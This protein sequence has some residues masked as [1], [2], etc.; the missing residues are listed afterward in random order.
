MPIHF[1]CT[2]C[3]RCCQ[4]LKLPLSVPEAIAWLARGGD[5]QLLCEAFAWPG[6]YDPTPQAAYG[7]HRSF[8]AVSD[9]VP[10]RIAVT[11]VGAFAGDCP[12]LLADKRC[13]GYDDRPGVCRIYPAEI[14]PAAMIDPQRKLCP[15][16]AWG[17]GGAV[18]AIDGT[19]VDPKTRQLIDRARAAGVEDI[20][21]KQSA[22]A[23]LGIADAAFANEGFAVHA[24]DATRLLAVLRS[25]A[26][27][28]PTTAPAW[29]IVT[30]RA[31]TLTMLLAAGADGALASADQPFGYH[32]FFAEEHLA[33]AA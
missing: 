18:L 26:E 24:P 10:V 27:Q 28:P 15:P 31:S 9:R 1:D 30:N 14:N 11:L 21:A 6:G 29:R 22:C 19:C 7:W 17:T 8:A 25:V 20:A 5:V 4:D 12:Y 23:L 13:G 32:G 3:G 33:A 16:D 2:M